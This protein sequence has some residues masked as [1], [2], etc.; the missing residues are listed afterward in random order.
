V[1]VARERAW[2]TCP[3][4]QDKA[5]RYQKLSQAGLSAGPGSPRQGDLP[6]SPGQGEILAE[7]LPGRSSVSFREARPENLCCSL[8]RHSAFFG[9]P[10]SQEHP[11]TSCQSQ[12]PATAKQP[13]LSHPAPEPQ[14]S[15]QAQPTTPQG[16]ISKQM[17]P[18]L[19]KYICFVGVI[20]VK[21]PGSVQQGVSTLF[22]PRAPRAR[23]T[24]AGLWRMA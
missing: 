22:A 6:G 9:A 5:K 11:A 15:S 8:L 4:D 17:S 12:L 13:Q 2:E 3:R 23:F 21:D 1:S 10:G 16:P 14:S 18:P 19:A 24:S 20:Y 7:A